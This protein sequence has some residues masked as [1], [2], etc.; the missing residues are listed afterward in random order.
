MEWW[1]TYGRNDGEM[2]I[3]IGKIQWGNGGDEMMENGKVEWWKDTMEWRTDGKV[4][5]WKD[6]GPTDGEME[7]E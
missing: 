1:E 7:T 3:F 2:G 5:N 6:V 4:N